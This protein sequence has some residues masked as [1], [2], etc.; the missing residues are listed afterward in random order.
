MVVSG[1]VD[2]QAVYEFEPLHQPL[3]NGS[4]FIDT[5]TNGHWCSMV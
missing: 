4:L 1:R 3:I 5:G 2:A